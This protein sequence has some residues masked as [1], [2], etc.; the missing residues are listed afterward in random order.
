MD[1]LNKYPED[2]ESRLEKDKLIRDKILNATREGSVVQ[3]IDR[4]AVIANEIG[5][6]LEHINWNSSP[7]NVVHEVVI[8]AYS[9]RGDDCYQLLSD[10]INKFY[11]HTK[12]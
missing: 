1:T 6:P 11:A 2:K 3:W 4:I 10:A 5:L 8:K 9:Y 7:I 12:K